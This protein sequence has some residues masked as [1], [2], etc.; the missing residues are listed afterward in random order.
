MPWYYLTF[1]S[2]SHHVLDDANL[3]GGIYRVDKNVPIFFRFL[4]LD[5]YNI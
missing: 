1:C 2:G 4:E 5:I 3:D